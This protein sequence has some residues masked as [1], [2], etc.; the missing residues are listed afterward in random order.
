MTEVLMYQVG[1]TELQDCVHYQH[2]IA[3]C[4]MKYSEPC[5]TQF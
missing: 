1:K 4:I 3:T 2:T 5:K